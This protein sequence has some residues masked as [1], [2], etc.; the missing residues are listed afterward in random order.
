ME[1]GLLTAV[2]RG[3][4]VSLHVFFFTVTYEN[5]FTLHPVGYSLFI[6]LERVT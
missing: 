4:S 3:M 5:I 6:Y 2:N 1:A